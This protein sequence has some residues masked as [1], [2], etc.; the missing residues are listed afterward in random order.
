MIRWFLQRSLLPAQRS[1]N[2][3]YQ[4]N[5]KGF[6]FGTRYV[7]VSLSV[8]VCMSLSFSLFI[9]PSPLSTQTSTTTSTH[10]SVPSRIGEEVPVPADGFKP[11]FTDR[12]VTRQSD[13][14]KNIIFE[15]RCIGDPKPS[16]TWQVSNVFVFPFFQILSIPKYY[17]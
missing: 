3:L 13:D 14:G 7:C 1:R 9:S 6:G 16:Y 11:A 10:F 4:A 2:V 5:N 8:C 17:R 12:P 15:C